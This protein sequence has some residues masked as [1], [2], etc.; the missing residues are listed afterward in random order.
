MFRMFDE[1]GFLESYRTC[2]KSDAEM[3]HVKQSEWKNKAAGSP[4]VFEKLKSQRGLTVQESDWKDR[5]Q[6]L[7]DEYKKQMAETDRIL[8]IDSDQTLME[9]KNMRESLEA[10]QLLLI[11]TEN[12]FQ[13]RKKARGVVDFQDLEQYAVQILTDPAGREEALSSWKYVFVDECQD[14]SAVQNHIISLLQNPGNHLFM[15]GDVKQSI[16][17]FRLADPILF[18]ER[19]QRCRSGDDR[20]TECIDLQANF[21]SRPE[22]LETTNLV[23]RSIMKESVTE[24]SYTPQEELIPGRKAEGREPVQAVRIFSDEK[25]RTDLEATAE[26]IRDE[27]ETLLQTPYPGKNRNYRYRDCV[28]LMPAVHTDGP[29]LADLLTRK[30]IPVF[31]DGSGDYYQL[32]EIQEIRNL[33]EWI[34]FPLQDLPFLSVLQGAPFWFSEEELSQIRLKRP[35]KKT[36]FHEAFLQ[37]SGEQSD[38]GRKCAAVYEKLKRWQ[39]LSEIMRV[40]DLIWELY[41]DTGI[42]YVLGADPAGEVKQA[43]LRMLAQEASQAESRGILTLRQF[44]AYMKDQQSYGDQQSATLLGDQDDLVRIM[45]IHKSKGLQFPVVFCAGMDKSPVGKDPSG[46]SAHARLGLCMNYKD[47][48]HRIS[49]PTLAAD[50]FAWQRRREEMAEKVRLLYVAMTRAQERLYLLTCQEVNPLWSM[51]EGEGRILAAKSFT[52]WWMPVFMQAE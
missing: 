15:V 24:I 38:L 52:D 36:A 7:R 39:D 2:W 21:R 27:I 32:R 28:V 12:L 50:I 26:F 37:Y 51:P 6:K 35:E 29:I 5:Y 25:N 3:F 44:L 43:N 30:K 1:P 33:L 23:F 10:V 40:S 17:R 31:F 41:R 49:R 22:I 46:I 9:W 20:K 48:E 45:T 16:Y 34:D 18:Q 4:C 8:L 11:R 13:T 42:Y 47:P 14:N 19:I